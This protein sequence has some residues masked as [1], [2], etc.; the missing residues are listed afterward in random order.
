MVLTSL[1]GCLKFLSIELPSPED[2]FLL[3]FLERDKYQCD[4]LPPMRGPGIKSMTLDLW[5]A[6]QPTE[7]HQPGLLSKELFI[8]VEVCPVGEKC[9][10][11]RGKENNA[12]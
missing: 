10:F 9:T 5:K 1:Q 8:G 6:F 7:P 12:N 4:W 2:I 11:E 3:L